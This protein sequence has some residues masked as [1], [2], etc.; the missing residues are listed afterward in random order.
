MPLTNAGRDYLAQVIFS[1]LTKFDNANAYIG[2]GDGTT[3]FDKTQTD[4]TGTNKF[5]KGM[6]TGF[7]NQS[8]VNSNQ[9]VFKSS[10]STSDANFTWQEYGI[11][12]AS[13]GGTML[14]RKQENIGSKTSQQVWDFT[15]TLTFNNP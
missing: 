14:C 10:F 1:N 3:A 6:V 5:R 12:N 11:F 2:V 8:G 9:V 15:V 13:T 7:P 4:L